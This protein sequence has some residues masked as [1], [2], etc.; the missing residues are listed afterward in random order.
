MSPSVIGGAISDSQAGGPNKRTQTQIDPQLW[1]ETTIR[2]VKDFTNGNLDNS[3]YEVIME[4][5]SNKFLHD[6]M[7]F[8]RTLVHFEIDD[9]TPIRLGF[10][11]NV[12]AEAFDDVN[13]LITSFEGSFTDINFDVGVWASYRSGGS[14]S[15][16]LAYQLLRKLFFGSAAQ[17]RLVGQSGI[18]IRS[19]TGGQFAQETIEDIEIFRIMGMALVLRVPSYNVS[20][21]TPFIGTLQQDGAIFVSDTVVIND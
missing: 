12:F 15:R 3:I 18:E 7:P 13:G 4:W 2:A 17:Q 21:P 19:F 8:E 5:P 1:L 20:L 6:Y 16:L 11:D 10:G 14:T 9:L